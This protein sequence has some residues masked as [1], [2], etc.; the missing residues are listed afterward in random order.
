[1][2]RML[3]RCAALD[4]HKAQVTVCVRILDAGGEIEE[5]SAVFSTMAPIGRTR[6]A[7]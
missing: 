5:L 1:M 2:R 3:E 7:R 4:V 6:P